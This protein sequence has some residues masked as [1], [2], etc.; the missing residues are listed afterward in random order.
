M[1]RRDW[2]GVKRPWLFPQARSELSESESVGRGGFTMNIFAEFLDRTLVKTGVFLPALLTQRALN[3]YSIVLP[4]RKRKDVALAERLAIVNEFE[5]NRSDFAE[6]F[7]RFCAGVDEQGGFGDPDVD[8]AFIEV[9]DAMVAVN[10]AM[11]PFVPTATTEIRRRAAFKEVPTDAAW[12]QVQGAKS[13]RLGVETDVEAAVQRFREAA[14]RWETTLAAAGLSQ[15]LTRAE[16]RRRKRN[17]TPETDA[18]FKAMRY[19][20]DHG[21]AFLRRSARPPGR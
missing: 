5:S 11:D 13:E 12:D 6:S 10:S 3:G 16:R 18:L 20:G 15:P 17:P 9:R 2:T 14:A 4:R 21:S 8:A 1:S 19:A 7:K